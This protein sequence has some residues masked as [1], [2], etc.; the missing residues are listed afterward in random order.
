VVILI[1][2]GDGTF[3]PAV[4]YDAEDFPASIFAADLDGDN[5][6]DIVTANWAVN[7]V[8]VLL[9]NGDGT[10]QTAV[11]YPAGPAAGTG[12]RDIIA[13]DLDGDNDFDLAVA[14]EGPDSVYVLLNNGDATFP[15]AQHYESG[16]TPWELKAA[17]LDDDGDDD[18]TVAM[19]NLDNIAVLLNNGNGA[20]QAPVLYSVGDKPYTVYPA[21][22]DCDGDEDLAVANFTGDSVSVL[23]NNGDA[24]FQIAENYISG[25][26][27]PTSVIA[28]D[29][30][31]DSNLDLAVA[32][33]LTLV[34]SKVSVLINLLPPCQCPCCIL[35][36]GDVNGDGI[37]NVADLTYIVDYLFQGGP[38]PLCE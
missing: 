12:A 8:S 28:A 20:F 16:G 5:D 27:S 35:S 13:A 32:H 14:N 38:P 26:T 11:N 15:P 37:S 19:P 1:N 7:S 17:D 30:D 4:N 33:Y 34:T 22:L 3:Q 24:T 21:D 25:V 31:G 18:L 9:N 2:N 6:N 23:W 10:L 29:F 36:P